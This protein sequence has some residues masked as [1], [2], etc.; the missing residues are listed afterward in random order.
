MQS[1]VD[2]DI[3]C[4]TL[5]KS[6]EKKN[7]KYSSELNY[8]ENIVFQFYSKSADKPPGK[9]AGEQIPEEDKYKY[10]ELQEIPNWRKVLSNFAVA[11]FELD[12]YRWKGVEWFYHAS[13]FKRNNPEFYLQFSLDSGSEISEDAKMA[14]AAGGKTGKFNKKQLRPKSVVMDPDFFTSK[15]NEVEMERAQMA[16]YSQNALA[17]RVL[18]ATRNAKLVHFVRASPPI[19]FYDSMRVRYKIST[20]R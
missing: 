8:D 2:N 7:R 16:K 11:P 15:R 17:K 3:K 18:L 14:K 6:T 13:K 20:Y 12:G 19:V 10:K 4:M 5:E 1:I 9:G